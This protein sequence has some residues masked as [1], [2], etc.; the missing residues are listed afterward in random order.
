MISNP[1]QERIDNIDIPA[2]VSSNH[3]PVFMKINDK[4][5]T[6]RNKKLLGNSTLLCQKMQT[7]ASESKHRKLEGQ[8]C[9]FKT[10][11]IMGN[12]QI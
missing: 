2:S 1:L 12:D 3:S 8:I 9:K 7:F 5:E 10:T 11:G 6:N 4:I